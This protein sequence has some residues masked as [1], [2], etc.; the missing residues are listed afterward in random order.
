MEV[1][2]WMKSG[3]APCVVGR[4]VK[5]PFSGGRGGTHPA[6]RIVLAPRGRNRPLPSSAE[7]KLPNLVESPSP[8]KSRSQQVPGVLRPRGQKEGEQK[9]SQRRTATGLAS[10]TAQWPPAGSPQ[11]REA[12]G[13]AQDEAATAHPVR[14]SPSSARRNEKEIP[15]P[16]P[17]LPKVQQLRSRPTT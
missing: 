1:G 8:S 9:H 4:R 11:L 12:S 14:S 7:S 17:A 10:G 13:K 5:S 16:S 15:S 2:G 6:N 3:A